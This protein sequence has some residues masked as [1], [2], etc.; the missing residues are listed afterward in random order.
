MRIYRSAFAVV[1]AW[2]FGASVLW[3]LDIYSDHA[4][5]FVAI[6]VLGLICI[7]Q[8]IALSVTGRRIGNSNSNNKTPPATPIGQP[9]T[10]K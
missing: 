1:M 3:A 10:T 6:V 8:A 2:V 7:I 9:I 5:N 4:G